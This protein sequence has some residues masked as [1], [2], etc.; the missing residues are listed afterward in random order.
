[1]HAR[2]NLEPDVHTVRGQGCGF[3]GAQ[4]S[5]LVDGDPKVGSVS[6]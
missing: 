3:K 2:I 4:L 6:R 1:M 5:L